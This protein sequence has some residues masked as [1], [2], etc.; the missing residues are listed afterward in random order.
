MTGGRCPLDPAEGQTPTLNG[1]LQH[2]IEAAKRSRL[3]QMLFFSATLTTWA[4]PK[5]VSLEE[6]VGNFVVD[7]PYQIYNVIDGYKV[8]TAK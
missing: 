8:D 2:L 1:R 5:T 7:C 4:P 3:D 6:G